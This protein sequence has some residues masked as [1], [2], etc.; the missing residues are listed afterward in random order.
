MN[1]F[2]KNACWRAVLSLQGL[3]TNEIL[4]MKK[5]LPPE[6]DFLNNLTA[7]KE[8]KSGLQQAL[9]GMSKLMNI[10]L[11]RDYCKVLSDFLKRCEHDL[12]LKDEELLKTWFHKKNRKSTKSQDNSCDDDFMSAL[13]DLAMQFQILYLKC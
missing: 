6:L 12:D 8:S 2:N 13:N 10:N 1:Y 9:K 11:K 3:L 4:R 7:T 5:L